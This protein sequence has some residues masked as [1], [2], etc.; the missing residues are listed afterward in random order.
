[1][2]NPYREFL[3]KRALGIGII[4]SILIYGIILVF[5]ILDKETPIKISEDS[6]VI[7]VERLILEPPK[8]EKIVKKLHKIRAKIV[9]NI[10]PDTIPEVIEEEEPEPV[11]V[12][13]ATVMEEAPPPPPAPTISKDSL[14]KVMKTY[15][16]SLSR[17]FEKRKEYPS[18]AKRLKQEGEVRIRFTLLK[19]GSLHGAEIAKPCPYSSLN[20]SA[21]KA[22]LSVTQFTPIPDILNKDVWK[23]EIPIKYT[24]H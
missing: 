19:D 5:G 14:K 10:V 2:K 21:L 9:P 13:T 20:K 15:L 24:L 18:T 3:Q 8:Q 16:R 23:M 4:S 17:E 1:M 12:A 7:R 22:V 6:N 11:I